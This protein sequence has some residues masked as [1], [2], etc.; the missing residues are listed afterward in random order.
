MK[1]MGKVYCDFYDKSQLAEIYF[2]EYR[3]QT[4]KNRLIAA[5]VVDQKCQPTD[6]NHCI[7]SLEVNEDL[8]KSS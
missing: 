2:R 3:D 5:A 7:Q 8:S 4:L 6:A 1:N